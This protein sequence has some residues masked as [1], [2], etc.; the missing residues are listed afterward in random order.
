LGPCVAGHEDEILSLFPAD[1]KPE[2]LAASIIG[3]KKNM[4]FFDAGYGEPGEACGDKSLAQALSA[5]RP[6]N[7]EMMQKSA[8]TVMAAKDRGNYFSPAPGYQTKTGISTQVSGN[9]WPG[10]G[11]AQARPLTATPERESLPVVAR[12]HLADHDLRRCKVA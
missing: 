6:G 10:I 3:V 2:L 7:S 4:A 8:A 9:G 12:R 5:I 11:T 1:P